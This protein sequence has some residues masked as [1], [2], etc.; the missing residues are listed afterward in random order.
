[1]RP[2]KAFKLSGRLGA[3]RALGDLGSGHRSLSPQRVEWC[4]KR[5]VTSFRGHRLAGRAVGGR[6][7]AAAGLAGRR[8]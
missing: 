5:R 3:E 4:M 8:P 1:M 7:S 2:N 6:E